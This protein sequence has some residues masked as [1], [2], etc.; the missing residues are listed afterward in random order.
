MS[1]NAYLEGSPAF[2]KFGEFQNIVFHQ[3]LRPGQKHTTSR[4]EAIVV[5]AYKAATD[6]GASEGYLDR[7]SGL[8]SFMMLD[9]AFGRKTYELFFPNPEY[10]DDDS[11]WTEI[12][13]AAFAH[14]ARILLA[15]WA[16]LRRQDDES[17]VR[18]KL[19]NNRVAGYLRELMQFSSLAQSIISKKRNKSRAVV[20]LC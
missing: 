14:T 18:A 2:K 10:S 11:R 6:G 12:E 17:T 5:K 15:E 3:R 1:A 4:Q 20:V 9:E 19:F 13:P 7:I 16:T 8:E